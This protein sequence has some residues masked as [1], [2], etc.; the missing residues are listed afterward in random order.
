MSTTIRSAR[1]RFVAVLAALAPVAGCTSGGDDEPR[2]SACDVIGVSERMVSERIINGTECSTRGSP[3]VQLTILTSKGG[4]AICSGSLLTPTKVL[5]AAHCYPS[6]VTS[7]SV[8]VEGRDVAV[9]SYQLHPRAQV[10]QN[11]L[12]VVTLASPASGTPTLPIILSRPTE[13]GDTISIFGY[14]Q[15]EEPN[16]TGVLRSGQMRVTGINSQDIS[17]KYTDVGS[18]TCFGD[19]GG[20]ALLTFRAPDGSSRTGIVGVVSYGVSAK[21][22]SGDVSAFANTQSNSAVDFIT[23]A[24]PGV[25]VQ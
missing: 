13:I 9:A 4:I 10:P 11:D 3:I 14:G 16:T 12:A 15:T 20:P 19:S 23:S 17:A 24:V 21:C 7:S 8:L 2:T 18:N 25:A 1:S 22:E 6:D 5:T